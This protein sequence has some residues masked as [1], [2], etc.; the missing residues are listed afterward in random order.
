MNR[1][2]KDMSIQK[3][4]LMRPRELDAKTSTEAA[5]AEIKRNSCCLGKGTGARVGLGWL[6][7]NLNKLIDTLQVA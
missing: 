3:T 6:K 4:N 5:R 2:P 7:T 1:E